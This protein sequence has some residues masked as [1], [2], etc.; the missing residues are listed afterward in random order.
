MRTSA[1]QCLIQTY[2][3]YQVLVIDPC[4]HSFPSR[5]ASKYMHLLRSIRI[6]P[7]AIQRSEGLL[8]VRAVSIYMYVCKNSTLRELL[9]DFP[10]LPGLL[11]IYRCFQSTP[12]LAVHTV[13]V[14]D[15]LQLLHTHERDSYIFVI[16]MSLGLRLLCSL[17]R[18]TRGI[19]RIAVKVRGK[20]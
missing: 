19:Y 11:G 8:H 16:C 4:I 1:A 17:Q 3:T 13:V 18:S 14:H 7:K 5:S 15:M 10:L 6:R 9:A 20:Q 12:T 2:V